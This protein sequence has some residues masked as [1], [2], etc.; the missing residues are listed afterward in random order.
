L[1]YTKFIGRTLT[2]TV[3]LKKAVQASLPLTLICIIYFLVV[4]IGGILIVPGIIAA[5]GWAV[6]GPIYLHENTTLFGSFGRSWE[7]THGYKLMIWV[8]KIII[9]LIL[10]VTIFGLIL[11]AS[12]IAT[13]FPGVTS[14]SNIGVVQGLFQSLLFSVLIY[15]FFSFYAAYTS[16][17]YTELIELKEGAL[18]S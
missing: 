17:L 9:A 4:Q 13:L 12:A 14:S 7:L 15:G 2:F 11:L 1:S 16:A 3:A 18:P 5:L 6:A 10:A 8:T